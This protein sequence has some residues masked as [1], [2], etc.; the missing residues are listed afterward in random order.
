M[1]W[2]FVPVESEPAQAVQ[3]AVDQF[4]AVAI[5]VGVFDSQNEGAAQVAGKEPVEQRR[6]GATDMQIAGRRGREP[7]AGRDRATWRE[8]V[9][10]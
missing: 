7:D 4:G 1:E 9:I 10:E 6:A 8:R 3:D 2:A 5:H